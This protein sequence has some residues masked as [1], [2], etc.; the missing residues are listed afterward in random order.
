MVDTKLSA[1]T[2][3]TAL[4]DADELY[5]ND[6]GTSK[7]I[8][9]LNAAES[10]NPFKMT[11]HRTLESGGSAWVMAGFAVGDGWG[12][13]GIGSTVSNSSNGV[14]VLPVFLPEGEE[15]DALSVRV[16]TASDGDATVEAALY[17]L[18]G[19][20]GTTFA[21]LTGIA[22]ASVTTT[23]SKVM[24]LGASYTTVKSGWYFVGVKMVHTTAT[25]N[26]LIAAHS[27]AWGSFPVLGLANTASYA[28]DNNGLPGTV[29]A[30]H[31]NSYAS[32]D[33]LPTSLSTGTWATARNM[34][35]Q[36]LY[37]GVRTNQ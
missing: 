37:L 23:G 24:V 27:T 35:H 13:S 5:V 6:G 7:K 18:E 25:I 8:T 29:S 31:T 34:Q 14:Y 20:A 22:S 36:R 11:V 19:L 33:S 10:V 12:S 3:V 26:P 30:K 15:V 28:Q 32:S 4:T 2:A 1:L 17:D 21:R 9:A 16:N